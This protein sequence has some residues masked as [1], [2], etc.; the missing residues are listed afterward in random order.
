MPQTLKEQRIH[1]PHCG[2]HLG[3]TLDTSKG[4]QDYYENCPACCREIHLTLHIDDQ[5]KKVKLSIESGDEQI[6]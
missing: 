2:H 1:C 4:D 6:F 5:H 3:V